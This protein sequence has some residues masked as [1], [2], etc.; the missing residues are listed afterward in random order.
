MGHYTFIFEEALQDSFLVSQVVAAHNQPRSIA[1]K[2]IALCC[3]EIVGNMLG[4]SAVREIE[5][6]S[7][8]DSPMSWHT[9]DIAVDISTQ[10]RDKPTE[11]KV[12]GL[13]LDG[14][15]NI[16]GKAQL[17]AHVRCLEINSLRKI[18]SLRIVSFLA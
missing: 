6:I 17:L 5:R 8:Y 3:R 13:Q 1:E 7:I 10:L 18:K 12:F 9:N 11:S 4:K 2:F 15:V 14:S 16:T